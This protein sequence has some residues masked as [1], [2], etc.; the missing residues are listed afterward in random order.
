MNSNNES[1]MTSA[2]MIT[3]V[4]TNIEQSSLEKGNKVVNAWRRT[5]ES[6]KPNGKNIAAHSRIIDLKNGILLIEADHP[7]WIQLLQMHQK[8]VLTG[9]HR[10]APDVTIHTLSFRLAGSS[11]QL[12]DGRSIQTAKQKE[13]ARLES[14]FEKEAAALEAQGFG[15]NAVAGDGKV[16]KELPPELKSLFDRFKSEMKGEI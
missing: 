10:L 9:L 1:V 7:G 8:Y 14:Q 5:V 3:R 2:D 6:V 12:T 15:K 11:V 16:A 4:F 13:R